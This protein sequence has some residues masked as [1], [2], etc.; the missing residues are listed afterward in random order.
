MMTLNEYI[1]SLMTSIARARI[2]SDIESVKI[3]QVYNKDEY[4][5]HFPIPRMRIG[6]IEMKI[7]VAFL[8]TQDQD[9]NELYVVKVNQIKNVVMQRLSEWI[10]NKTISSTISDLVSKTI[11]EQLTY[12]RIITK[13]QNTL[14]IEEISG[15]VAD[16]V[17]AI[18]NTHITSSSSD[19]S[20]LRLSLINNITE[21]LNQYYKYMRKDLYIVAEAG[22]LKEY[23][24]ESI[25]TINLKMYEDALEWS[26]SSERDGTLREAL[27]SE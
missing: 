9:L 15:T 23:P 20:K 21:E 8:A 12:N 4:L 16:Q 2:T 27:I 19:T 22:K 14:F 1:G 18:M 25:I 3:A 11:D 26:R 24:P 13:W 17:I 5:K 6:D 7:P 10:C